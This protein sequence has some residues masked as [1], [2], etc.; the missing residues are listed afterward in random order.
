MT[1]EQPGRLECCTVDAK[2]EKKCS[3]LSNV[4]IVNDEFV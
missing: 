1:S 4:Q 2:T 3:D